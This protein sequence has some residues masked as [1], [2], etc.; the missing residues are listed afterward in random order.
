[1]HTGHHDVA[2]WSDVMVSSDTGHPT[3]GPKSV[4]CLNPAFK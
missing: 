2:M 3:V 1:M 4:H